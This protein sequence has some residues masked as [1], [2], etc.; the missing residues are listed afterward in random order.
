MLNE[1]IDKTCNVMTD[2]KV[3][4]GVLFLMGLHQFNVHSNLPVLGFFSRENFGDMD[5]F[6]GVTPLKA[7]GA[8]AIASSICMIARK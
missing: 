5:L 1:M 7:L 4:A 2:K 6:M 3:V 8:I